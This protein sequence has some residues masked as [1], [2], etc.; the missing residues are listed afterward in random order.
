M[1][2]TDTLE[3]LS[4][5]IE[6]LDPIGKMTP[7][8]PIKANDWNT[9]VDS[10]RKVATLVV[11]REKTT[12]EFLDERFAP[13]NHA[14]I[15]AASLDWFESSTR[16]LL[17]DATQGS[18]DVRAAMTKLEGEVASLRN[19]IAALRNAIDRVRGD[20]DGLRDSDFARGRSL[21]RFGSRIQAIS[22]TADSFAGLSDRI[23]GMR[24]G[25]QEALDF[26]ATLQD[27]TGR[28]I[29]VAELKSRVGS[30]ESLRENL[31]LASGEVVRIK[32]IESAL[33]RLED[34]AVREKD[35]DEAVAKRI[36]DGSL[37]DESQIASSIKE[38]IMKDMEERFSES[39]GK[40]SD[41]RESVSR[42]D[43]R[44]AI[45]ELAMSG[46]YERIGGAETAIKSLTSLSDIASAH[47]KTLNDHATLLA[48]HETALASIPQMDSRVT[49]LERRTASIG[50]LSESLRVA[51]SRITVVE[52]MKSKVD[53]LGVSIDS[54][55]KRVS[56]VEIKTAEIDKLKVSVS[57]LERFAEDASKRFEI[58]GAEIMSINDMNARL[59]AVEK[60][61]AALKTWK[62][63]TDLRI[64]GL[65][66]GSIV[67]PT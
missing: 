46:F 63:T 57:N 36:T 52:G 2:R 43:G 27:E 5:V 24:K 26:K 10:L 1:A 29:D 20:I 16:K 38:S 45:Q 50:T 60:D 8:I 17:T 23:E 19:D 14:H 21:E 59:L 66:R 58:Y 3:I 9:L 31:T 54:V 48:V 22:T 4:G 42:L 25:I 7:G 61:S 51:E 13:V 33:A 32:E 30:L 11:A 15:G 37:L 47:Q 35:L 64:E 49:M 44:I 67:R 56:A 55:S 40:I 62:G 18:V 53:E 28:I 39:G 41:I 12:S 65:V 6:K 34:T